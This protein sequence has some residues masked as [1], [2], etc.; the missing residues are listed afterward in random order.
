[1]SLIHRVT[2]IDGPDRELNHG[3][4]TVRSVRRVISYDAFHP[5][6]TEDTPQQDHHAHS[7][8]KTVTAYKVSTAKRIGTFFE[9][10]LEISQKKKYMLTFSYSAGRVY[11]SGLLAGFGHR[12]RFRGVEARVDRC[13]RLSGALH[14][15]GAGGRCGCVL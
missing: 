14:G 5:V 15:G 6:P 12:I 7:P 2:S 9:E 11:C 4:G 13:G 10:I 1:M 3:G 8:L